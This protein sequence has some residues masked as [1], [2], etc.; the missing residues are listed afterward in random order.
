MQKPDQN[1]R[2]KRGNWINS[3]HLQCAVIARDASGSMSEE[4]R[5]RDASLATNE[6]TE[7]LA[8]PANKDG[9][10]LGIVDFDVDV[11]QMVPMAKASVMG[12]V[13]D[14]SPGQATNITAGLEKAE[15][16][17]EAAENDASLL[18]E[19]G[20]FLDHLVILFSDGGHNH[21]IQ[22]PEEVAKRMADKGILVVTVA[23][24][25]YADKNRLKAL[26]SKG[27]MFAECRTGQELRQ[28]FA[29]VGGTLAATVA[30]GTSFADGFL[31]D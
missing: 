23:F 21:G 14:I 18:P 10:V 17:L 25:K 28:F 5:A 4:N 12:R 19:G 11:T 24:G 7:E 16:L 20:R 2:M 3:R 15:Q 22:E 8:H 30:A 6:L 13:T 26:S 31:A 1:Q 27:Q 29:Q 9:F